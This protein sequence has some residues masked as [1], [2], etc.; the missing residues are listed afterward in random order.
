LGNCLDR[1]E[2]AGI[3]EPSCCNKPAKPVG[4]LVELADAQ[5]RICDSLGRLEK[6]IQHY[7][8]PFGDPSKPIPDQILLTRREIGDAYNVGPMDMH[9]PLSRAFWRIETLAWNV[10]KAGPAYAPSHGG[11]D[12]GALTMVAV[13]E[14]KMKYNEGRPYMHNKTA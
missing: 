1:F 13:R 9:L 14:L 4:F 6:D 5:I 8:L 2:S 10:L 12:T 3:T 7:V 11:L